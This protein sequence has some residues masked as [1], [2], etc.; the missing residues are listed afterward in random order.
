MKSNLKLIVKN[1]GYSLTGQISGTLIRTVYH[2]I[3]ANLLGAASYGLYSLGLSVLN[4]L[5]IIS[6][7]G[8]NMT[9]VKFIPEYNVRRDY[10]GIRG[11]V[12]FSLFFVG[13]ISLFLSIL[14]FIF[15]KE[16]AVMVFKKQDLTIIFKI[17]S[18]SLTI[19]SLLILLTS[20]FRAFKR[21]KYSA[22]ISDVIQPL[23]AFI[24]F[25]ILF[26][27]KFGIYA[28]I[29]SYFFSVGIAFIVGILLLN[30]KIDVKVF[31]SKARREGGRL[32]K[33]S[34]PIVFLYFMIRLLNRTDI[35]I[36]G[37]FMQAKSVGIYAFCYR[38]SY[39]LFL[40]WFSFNAIFSPVLSSL[41]TE[42]KIKE[43][44][45]IFKTVSRWVFTLTLPFAIFLIINAD[46][47]L[48]LFKREFKEGVSVLIIFSIMWLLLSFSGS[49][50]SVL[51]MVGER[52]KE[53]YFTIPIVL[54]NI[55][56]NLLFIPVY[57]LKGAAF[58]T[59]ISIL[60]FNFLKMVYIKKK[61]GIFPIDIKYLSPIMASFIPIVFLIFARVIFRSI[62]DN[63]IFI[64]TLITIELVLFIY[65]LILLKLP[66]EDFFILSEIKLKLFGGEKG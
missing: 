62:G 66:K 30:S 25:L 50:G 7:F 52:E 31:N 57:G 51:I 6:V 17:F 5:V 48:G 46:L 44:D 23:S 33:F 43:I 4:I 59:M 58:A 28:A 47:I 35:L 49:I 1:A 20:I 32:L 14:M 42:G 36:I 10:E 2:I 22:L 24:I 18:I 64:F 39:L 26:Y 56:L 41:F 37:Y 61:I 19:K 21:L 15:S 16:I 13:G 60:S 40:F 9:V 53:L 45:M 34:L 12:R 11:V 27:L 63:L 8:L 54:V 55:I 65:F 38:I 3:I 29:Y